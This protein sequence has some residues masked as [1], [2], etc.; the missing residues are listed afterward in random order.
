MT[1]RP[2]ILRA[3]FPW[4]GGKSRVADQ[5]WSLMG[6]P[7][8]YV[9][10]FAGSLAVLLNRPGGG[11]GLEVVN[12]ADAFIVNVWRSLKHSPAETIRWA[13]DLRTEVDLTARHLWLV[14][15]GRERL[16]A[17]LKVDVDWHDPQ[18]AGWWLYGIAMWIGTGFCRGDGP[19][20]R[21]SIMHDAKLPHLGSDGRGV[22][23]QLPHL[24]DDGRG[25][26]AQLPHLGTDGQ[27][28]VGS[29]IYLLANRLAARLKRVLV[30]SGDFER[31]LSDS[32]LRSASGHTAVFLDPP[33]RQHGSEYGHQADVEDVWRRMTAWCE[34]NGD[35]PDYRIVVCGYEGDWEPPIGWREIAYTATG[36][37]TENR[38]RERMWVSRSCIGVQSLFD[39]AVA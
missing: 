1:V 31:V 6:N 7:G 25:V 13:D 29:S 10:P 22:H 12:D 36:T 38:I 35:R 24:G 5:A 27:G 15:E 33:Y 30:T 34:R 9:E 16:R 17:G 8:R 28:V 2:D 18:V 23:A 26:H 11:N 14:N 32:A 19:H 4:Y 3:P 37:A 20:T 39:E 21:Q